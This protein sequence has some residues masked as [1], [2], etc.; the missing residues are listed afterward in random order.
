MTTEFPITTPGY[1]IVDQYGF[2]NRGE[3]RKPQNDLGRLLGHSK[4]VLKK[5]K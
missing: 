3:S 2:K 5:D 1:Y 4:V